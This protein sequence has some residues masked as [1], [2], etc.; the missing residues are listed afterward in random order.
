MDDGE[1][2]LLLPADEGAA[3]GSEGGLVVRV[4]KHGKH[5][6][7]LNVE[8]LAESKG[9]DR[10]VN[11]GLPRAAITSLEELTVPAAVSQMRLNSDPSSGLF[12]PLQPLRGGALQ[13]PGR[14]V[15]TEAHDAEHRHLS[16]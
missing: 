4:E 6:L 5:I 12:G 15:K 11:L 10:S 9:D 3:A 14:W 8:M 1:L 16:G 2:P 7:T 13:P